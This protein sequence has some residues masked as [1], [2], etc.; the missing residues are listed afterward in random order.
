MAAVVFTVD[1][2][3][4]TGRAG[5]TERGDRGGRRRQR[6]RPDPVRVGRPAPAPMRS[7][8]VRRLIARPRRPRLQ[9]PPQHPG[10]LPERPRR[11]TRSTR[12]SRRP[13][14]RRS[15]TP[16]TRASARACPGGG[17][18]RLKYSNPMYVD[19]V[20]VD[21]PDLTIVL[22]H[23]SFP[24][25]DEAI[26]VA[27]HKQQVYIDLSGLVAEVLPAAARPLREH[28]A[29]RPRPL[30]LRL[31]D[32]HPR[33]L[34]DGLRAGRVQGRGAAADPEGERGAAARPPVRTQVGIVGAG[35]AGLTLAQLL[36][37]RR[38]RDR[39]C[40]RAAAATTSRQ[41]IRAGVLEQG[42]VDLLRD[43][44]RRRAAG[45]R[46]HRPRRH[47]PPVRRR[48]PPRA[49]GRAHRRPLDRRSTGRRRS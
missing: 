4:V 33:S 36:D 44:R 25:Q 12:R 3:T 20:A 38:H 40:S 1:A 22:A 13:A 42:T 23:P 28:P 43:A 41:R 24:W 14:C 45:P 34:A 39:S 16:A 29:A 46:G 32:D 26:S 5:R 6:G 30:R 31:P 48:A 17:G 9:V 11:S 21:F 2:E 47:L 35:P 7:S 49:D 27:L 18:I 10:V 15:S 37:R 19:D 8:E